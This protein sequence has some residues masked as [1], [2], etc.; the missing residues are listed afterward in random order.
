MHMLS[1]TAGEL[2]N[3][4]RTF[5]NVKLTTGCSWRQTE[6]HEKLLLCF[7]AFLYHD[8]LYQVRCFYIN[9]L[10]L[11]C[12][13]GKSCSF[14]HKHKVHFR[15]WIKKV[16]RVTSRVKH[17]YTYLISWG[18]FGSVRVSHLKPQSQTPAR[19]V[20]E[21]LKPEGM[22]VCRTQLPQPNFTS[23]QVSEI[24][25]HA[26]NCWTHWPAIIST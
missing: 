3:K 13:R 1:I 9:H 18:S 17:E 16:I 7:L 20:R 2:K 15:R 11:A 26:A 10:S 8:M 14:A 4:P 24:F 23:A 19:K 12:W 25:L 21:L 6:W 22:I 5:D